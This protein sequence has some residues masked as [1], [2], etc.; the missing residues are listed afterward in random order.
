MRFT[1]HSRDMRSRSPMLKP[2]VPTNDHLALSAQGTIEQLWEVTTQVTA[3]KGGSDDVP[4]VRN[5]VVGLVE[6]PC[7]ATTHR[8]HGPDVVLVYLGMNDFFTSG[9]GVGRGDHQLEINYHGRVNHNAS[10]VIQ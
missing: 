10:L 9:Q 6:Q 7:C 2:A 4:C 5:V 3:E 1:V 8:L